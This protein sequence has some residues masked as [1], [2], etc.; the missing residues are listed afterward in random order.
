MEL[1]PRTFIVT[2]TFAAFVMAIVFFAQ[3]RTFPESIK[4]FR[5]WGRALIVATFAAGLL[6]ARDIIPDALS[7]VLGNGLLALSLSLMIAAISTFHNRPTPWKVPL[8]CIAFVVLAMIYSVVFDKN[9]Q[10][11]TMAASAVNVILLGM[12]AWCTFRDHGTYRFK[13]G[14]LFSSVCFLVVAL[15]SFSR[16]VTLLAGGEGPGYVGLLAESPM[17]RVYLASYSINILLVS[18]GFS[19]MGHEKLVENYQTLASRD[20]LTGLYNRRHIIEA[21]GKEI[22]RAE[23]YHRDISLIL[24]DIDNF[25]AIND[26]YGHQAGDRVINHMADVMRETFREIDLFGRYGGEE[27]I[28]LLPETQ[29][30]DAVVLSERMR[31]KINQRIVKFENSEIT[32]SASF[33]IAQGQPGMQLDQLIAQADKALYHAKNSGRNRVEAYLVDVAEASCNKA[34]ILATYQVR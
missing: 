23:R 26:S 10:I 1:D 2:T 31:D 14:T 12:A 24:I 3:A 16:L 27:F 34:R 29:A 33:G 30:A 8:A 20:D 17:Q 6:A 22:Q 11:R 9:A 25:K 28:A 5:T 4:G 32:Y 19:I 13:F 21:A 18:V 15:I 7:V